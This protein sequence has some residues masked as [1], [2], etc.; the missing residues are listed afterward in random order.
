[1]EELSKFGEIVSLTLKKKFA[2]AE[3]KDEL[4]PIT[5]CL[6]ADKKKFTIE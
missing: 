2:F 4:Q 5:A 3:F 1:L 6:N